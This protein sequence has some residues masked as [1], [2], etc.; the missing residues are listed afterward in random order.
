[1]RFIGIFLLA[2]TIHACL[3]PA[4]ARHGSP[5][6]LP[7]ID[8][9]RSLLGSKYRYGG[10]SPRGFDCSG[11]TH[12]VF[13][14]HNI[15]LPRT[16]SEQYRIGKK[17]SRLEARPGDLVFFIDKGRINHVAIVSQIK[18]GDLYMIHSTTSAGVI[19]ENMNESSY[20]SRRYKAIRRVHQ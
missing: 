14:K 18:R 16:S 1:M 19:E 15:N 5:A 9:A 10:A 20:W 12:Y 4:K 8:T 2:L 7:W 13:D 6:D 3:A 11:L 17:I